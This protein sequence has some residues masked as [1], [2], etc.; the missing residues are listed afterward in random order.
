[1]PRPRT[2]ARAAVVEAA[3][4]A[5]WEKGYEGTPISDLER[6]TGLNRSSLYLAF[7]GKRALFDEALDRYVADFIDPLIGTMEVVP[8]GL[9]EI[10]AFFSRVRDVLIDDPSLA[11]R[12]CLMVNTIAELSRRDGGAADRAASFRDRLQ[13]AFAHALEGAAALGD[14]DGRTVQRRASI[15]AAG[16]LGIWL[17]ARIDPS[18]AA[19][20]CTAIRWEVGSWRRAAGTTGITAASIDRR[21]PSS[22][23]SLA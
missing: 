17:S 22:P 20:L 21:D 19:E 2:F 12:G 10:S 8:A 6:G 15:L 11:G 18:H 14:V 5:F 9:G 4:N 13:R 1:M 3:K 7:G 16:T 23:L